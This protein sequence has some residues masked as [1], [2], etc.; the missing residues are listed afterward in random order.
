M[1]ESSVHGR[2]P[3]QERQSPW[4][5]QAAVEKVP[6]GATEWEGRAAPMP[7]MPAMAFY[8]KGHGVRE[9]QEGSL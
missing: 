3:R 1:N 2:H 7:L 8:Q 9:K 5:C 4:S 6:C